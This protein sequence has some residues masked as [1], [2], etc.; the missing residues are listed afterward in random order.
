MDETNESLEAA[1]ESLETT[2]EFSRRTF[3]VGGRSYEVAYNQKRIELYEAGHRPIMAT[4]MSNGGAFSISELKSLMAYGLKLEG[5]AYI[6]PKRGEEMASE[7][8]AHNGYLAVFECV[9]EAL[10]NDCG[11]LFAGTRS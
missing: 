1:E 2:E 4:F 9:V 11:F 5:G 6:N 8:I 7:L 10:Q 3:T